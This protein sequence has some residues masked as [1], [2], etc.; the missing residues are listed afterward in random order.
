MARKFKPPATG[1]ECYLGLMG[2]GK[3]LKLFEDA[4]EHILHHRRPYYTNLPFRFRLL[5]KYLFDR[6]GVAAAN[7]IEPLEQDHFRAFMARFKARSEFRHKW[8]EMG[9]VIR[10]ELKDEGSHNE[11]FTVSRRAWVYWSP[12]DDQRVSRVV[13]RGF[14]AAWALHREANGLAA[15]KVSGVG[16]NWIPPGAVIA[17]DEVHHWF[18]SGQTAQKES[19]LLAFLTMLRHGHYL[20]VVATQHAGQVHVAFRRLASCF[21]VAKNIGEEPIHLG[22]KW[23]YLGVDLLLYTKYQGEQTDDPDFNRMPEVDRYIR[24]HL[25]PM[26]KWKFRLYESFT[27]LAS[28]RELRRSM[29]DA[30]DVAGVGAEIKLKEKGVRKVKLWQVCGLLGLGCALGMVGDRGV[31]LGVAV[32]LP[33]PGFV[34]TGA[35]EGFVEIDGVYCDG[36]TS[37]KGVSYIGRRGDDVYLLSGGYVFVH[38]DGET[39]NLGDRESVVSV[40]RSRSGTRGRPAGGVAGSGGGPAAGTG[41]GR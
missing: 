20:V 11:A 7:L 8:K 19:D 9:R 30:R 25:L 18:A 29:R 28:G 27:H 15:E 40:L 4:L 41:Q 10:Y 36:E 34:V 26:H 12:G 32:D 13:I 35:G 1:V 2:S 37:V 3:S 16:A 21:W 31:D 17:I 5:R 33:K 23:K 22:V 14:E 6:G 38:R 24:F 39:K